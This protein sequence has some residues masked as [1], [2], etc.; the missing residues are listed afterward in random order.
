MMESEKKN[1]FLFAGETSADLYGGLLLQKLHTML[2]QA[3]FWGVGGPSMQLMGFESLIDMREFQVMGFSDVIKSLGRLIKNFRRIKRA[4]LE[5]QPDIVITIDQPSFGIRLA[6]SLKKAGFKGKI[7][8]FVAPTVWAYKP[9]RAATMAKCFDALLTLFDFESKYFAHTTLPTT[10]VGHPIVE[11][12]EKSPK[13]SLELAADKPI[14][15]LFPGSRPAEVKR[16]LKLQLEAAHLYQKRHPEIVIAVACKEPIPDLPPSIVQVPFDA[17]YELMER[18]TLAIA[19]SGTV[20]LELALHRVPT[21]VTYQLST[22]NYL[23]AKYVLRLKL[24]YFSIVNILWQ[25]EL[26]Y[27]QIY[28]PVTA[29]GIYS[30]LERYH[31]R[32]AKVQQAC[33]E[34]QNRLKPTNA[35]TQKAAEV[36]CALL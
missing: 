21:V 24:P 14:L 18:S 25:G 17:R 29:L 6:K 2:P 28:P 27:E 19:K 34:L 26:F 5:K 23:M 30:C 9:Q 13:T 3:S 22:L 32:Y 4:I 11:I 12:I 7:V 31:T 16:N 8:Q 33:R 1:I 35:P 36:I 20:T 15:A 10:F